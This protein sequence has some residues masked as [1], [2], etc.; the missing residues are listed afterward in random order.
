MVSRVERGPVADWM[1]TAD[2]WLPLRPGTELQ[3]LTA[4]GGILAD[5]PGAKALPKTVSDIFRTADVGDHEVRAY[6]QQLLDPR[7]QGSY[8]RGQ[9][10]ARNRIPSQH[11][12]GSES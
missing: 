5:S 2:R 12:A 11:L 8:P 10:T 1:R 4:L 3:F 7:V 9:V 6:W